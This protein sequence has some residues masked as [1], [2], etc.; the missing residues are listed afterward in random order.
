MRRIS[1]A[2]TSGAFENRTKSVTRRKWCDK[3]A[4][5]WQVGEVFR[6]VDKLRNSNAKIL[7]YGKITRKPYREALRNM[8]DDHFEREGGTQYWASKEAFI[9]AMGGPDAVYWVIEFEKIEDATQILMFERK[10]SDGKT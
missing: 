1:M 7:G 5:S 4:E 10:E 2:W 6:A 9:E 3:Y 8:P